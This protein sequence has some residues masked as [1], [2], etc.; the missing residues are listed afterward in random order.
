MGKNAETLFA[1]GFLP[2]DFKKP[3]VDCGPEINSL[4]IIS[5]VESEW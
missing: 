2:S 1:R 3:S 5:E 4:P